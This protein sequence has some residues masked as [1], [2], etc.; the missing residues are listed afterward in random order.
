MRN[1]FIKG[2]LASLM[3]S[4]IVLVC[5]LEIIVRTAAIELRSLDVIE[6]TGSQD[7]KGQVM[8]LDPQRKK[9]IYVNG[10]Q[11]QNCNQKS[12]TQGDLQH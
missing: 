1:K 2:A 5:R 9:Q 12:L 10:Q 8:V 4:V 11:S 7:G 6:T 3:G